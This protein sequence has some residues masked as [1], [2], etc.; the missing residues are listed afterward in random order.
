MEDK[1]INFIVNE[2]HKSENIIGSTAYWNKFK[3]DFSNVYMNDRGESICYFHFAKAECPMFEGYQYEVCKFIAYCFSNGILTVSGGT[4]VGGAMQTTN[5]KENVLEGLIKLKRERLIKQ[6][7]NQVGLIKSVGVKLNVY[8]LY[9]HL[10]CWEQQETSDNKNWV[11]KIWLN[12]Y[13]KT[14]EGV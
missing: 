4:D 12:S 1:F 10:I 7:K 14:E 6:L 13:F 3:R 8:K 5:R 9:E 2:F 11:K